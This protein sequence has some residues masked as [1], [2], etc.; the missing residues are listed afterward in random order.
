M[1]E[2]MGIAA[3]QASYKLAQLSS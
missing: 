2:Q 1:L 3:K